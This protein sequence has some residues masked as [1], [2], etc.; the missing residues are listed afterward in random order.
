MSKIGDQIYIIIIVNFQVRLE[1]KLTLV[2]LLYQRGYTRE[3][4][5]QLFRLIDWMMILPQELK[6]QFETELS[7]YEEE[8]KMPY[9]TS[10]ERSGIEKGTLKTAKESVIEVLETRFNE[11]PDSMANTLNNINDINRLKQLH[12]QAILI[13]S[14]ASFESLL[15]SENDN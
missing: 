3:R 5:I 7:Q 8:Q 12:K 2:R 10:I 6:T 1:N 15:S 13:E 4:I 11:I 14:L 9:I